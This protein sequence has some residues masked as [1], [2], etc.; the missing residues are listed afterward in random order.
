VFSMQLWGKDSGKGGYS[1]RQSTKG[2]EGA[3]G[4][5]S[6]EDERPVAER[7]LG[8]AMADMWKRGDV[9]GREFAKITI[10]DIFNDLYGR[11]KQLDI[12]TRE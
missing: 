7:M 11:E 4:S 8:E 1:T 3:S 10:D 9:I 12:K 2:L 6:P 5:G